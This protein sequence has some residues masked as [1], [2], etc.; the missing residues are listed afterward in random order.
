M[1]TKILIAT[2]GSELAD[3]GVEHGLELAKA[4]G[5]T[6]VLVTVTES[7]ASLGM[8]SEVE[9]A[10]LDAIKSYEEA[11]S[12]SAQSIL[13]AAGLKASDRNVACELLHIAD[14]S[15]A[16]AILE[17]AEEQ[18]CDLIIMASH[19]RRGLRRFLLGSQTGEVLAHTSKP[20]LVLR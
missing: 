2:D 6:A 13:K 16:E 1:Y 12:Q 7:W 14:Q 10:N 9:R 18:D 4:V 11:A 5:A 19:G 20:V 3:A 8:A 15:P 17:V